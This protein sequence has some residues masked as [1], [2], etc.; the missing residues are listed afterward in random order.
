MK[1]LICIY[2]EGNDTK[3]A[4]ISKVNGKLMVLKTAGVDF[5][6][7]TIDLEEGISNL[8][9][10]GAELDLEKI[11]N[12]DTAL[13]S[14]MAAST[15]TTLANNLA[16]INLKKSLFIPALTEPALHY[17]I[18][19]NTK[20]LA[21]TKVAGDIIDD[22]QESK[23]MV[24]DK[25]NLGY[26]ELADKSLLSVFLGGEVACINMINSLARHQGTRHFKIPSVK[27]AEIS[28]A[29]YVAKTK[30]FFPD[31][32]S[33]IV[34]IGKEYSKLIFLQGR[35]LKHIGATLDIGTLNLHTY[36]VY[37]SKI[38][39]EMENGGISSLD[40]IIVC[41]EDD[42]E[43][44]ILSFYGTFPEANVSRLEFSDIDL[45]GL[46]QEEK[47]KFSCFSVPVAVATEYYDELEKIHQGINLLPKYVRE[48][49]KIFQFGWHGYAILPLLFGVTFFATQYILENQQELNMLDNEIA[50]QTILLRQNQE[51]LTKIAEVETKISGFDQTQ[52]ILDSASTGTGAWQEV[53]KNISNF[54]GSRNN[55]W[56]T[57]LNFSG[58]NVTIEGYGL[59]KNVLT[60]FAYS[61]E[62]AILKSVNYETLREQNTYKFLLTFNL[63]NYQNSVKK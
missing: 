41:G 30:K 27:S 21:A 1:P 11:Q 28:L 63:S 32:Q 2:C 59:D 44:L 18:Y 20:Q 22:I 26:V 39:L 25:Q 48:D 51:I 60:E 45:G 61:I 34:Y 15:V 7:P 58:G 36:D 62:S 3:V 24:V 42:S 13:E 57:K 19:E 6:Q 40:N 56:I 12:Q 16:G 43:N 46:T 8:S 53:L 31:D 5:V 52:A 33:L 47:E 17:H 38:L 50:E 37:F 9:I 54:V 23:N 29:Y 55:M 35:K 10:E 14:K 4:V 49:Q